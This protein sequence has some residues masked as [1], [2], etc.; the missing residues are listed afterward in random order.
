MKTLK[1]LIFITGMITWGLALAISPVSIGVCVK[2]DNSYNASIPVSFDIQLQGSIDKKSNV[3]TLP[4]ANAS[5][6]VAFLAINPQSIKVSKH[7]HSHR[8]FTCNATSLTSTTRSIHVII[9]YSEEG[10]PSSCTIHPSNRYLSQDQCLS[11]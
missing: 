1:L 3:A 9:N 2:G 11:S 7:G 6:Y 5:D 4:S 8:A 10:L